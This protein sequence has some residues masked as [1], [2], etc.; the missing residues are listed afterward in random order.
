MDYINSGK[1]RAW[2]LAGFV[3]SVEFKDLCS[4]YGIVAGSLR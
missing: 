1:T 3:N 2:V 4:K